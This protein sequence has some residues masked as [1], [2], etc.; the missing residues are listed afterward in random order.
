MRVSVVALALV[1]SLASPAYAQSA[2]IV[3]AGNP[4]G[5]VRLL[6]QQGMAAKLDKDSYGDPTIE[7][8]LSGYKTS[9]LFYGCDE[10]TH[11]GCTSV[12]LRAGFDRDKPWTA[13]EAIGVTKKYRFVSIWLDDD[14]DP[15]VQW[16]II[17]GSGIP[18]AV[19]TE[20]LQQFGDTLVDTAEVVFAEKG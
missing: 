2:G 9:L 18:A 8:E 5:I 3:S 11:G 6:E 12:Q 14:G 10:N 20:A 19:F 13:A 7:F 16:D 17:T 1:A 15:W 4:A